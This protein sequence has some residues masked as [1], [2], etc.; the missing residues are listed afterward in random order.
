MEALSKSFKTLLFALALVV[1]V[2]GCTAGSLTGPVDQEPATEEVRTDEPVE[3]NG[4]GTSTDPG[5][6]HHN[7]SDT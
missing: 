6:N 7:L 5:G 4:D 2:T 1:A 3:T